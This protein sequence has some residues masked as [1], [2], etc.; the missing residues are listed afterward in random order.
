MK[1]YRFTV[2]FDYSESVFSRYR[3]ILARYLRLQFFLVLL[4]LLVIVLLMLVFD[5]DF[6]VR[7]AQSLHSGERELRLLTPLIIII[8]WLFVPL[9]F[10]ACLSERFY[11]KK[12]FDCE[13]SNIAEDKDAVLSLS[14]IARSFYRYCASLEMEDKQMIFKDKVTGLVNG[15]LELKGVGRRLQNEVVRFKLSLDQITAMWVA[16]DLIVIRFCW[17]ETYRCAWDF[18]LDRSKF[19]EGTDK[20]FIKYVEKNIVYKPIVYTRKKLE[21]QNGYARLGNKSTNYKENYFFSLTQRDVKV[22]HVFWGPF[23]KRSDK[24]KKKE[25][26]E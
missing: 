7:S 8:A 23:K 2:G 13:V 5:P 20:A 21:E 3:V 12:R 17:G 25:I 9:V 6:F 1:A 22:F 16:R 19:E 26:K 10:C 15:N 24:T 11:S 4:P 18:I 14:I